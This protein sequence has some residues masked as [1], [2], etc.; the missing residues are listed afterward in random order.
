VRLSGGRS[1]SGNQAAEDQR[2]RW[3]TGQYW[4]NALAE[5][6]FSSLKGELID[7]RAWPTQAGAKRAIVE[8]I[9]WS[10]GSRLHS[11]LGYRS[12]AQL[13]NDHQSDSPV[14]CRIEPD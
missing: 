6:F 4:N 9:A 2:R 13:E 8:Y 12:P 14:R 3:G 10:N 11:S 1:V 5:S 7:T